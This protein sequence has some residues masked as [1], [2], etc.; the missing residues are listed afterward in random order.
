MEEQ[1]RG[2]PSKEDLAR[3][4]EERQFKQN[5]YATLR[6]DVLLSNDEA[7]AL[8]DKYISASNLA[9]TIRSG[10]KFELNDANKEQRL[11]IFGLSR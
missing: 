1:K 7:K 2:R 4:E 3:R 11:K 9:K 8:T 10:E 5:L 6:E